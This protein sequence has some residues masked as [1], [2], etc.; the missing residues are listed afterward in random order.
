MAVQVFLRSPVLVEHK[1]AGIARMHVQVVLDAALF[2]AGGFEQSQDRAAKV[3]FFTGFRL[4]FGDNG[5]QLSHIDDDDTSTGD[6]VFFQL[7][8]KG[9]AADSQEVRGDGA[10]PFGVFEGMN[11]GAAF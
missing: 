6:F 1:A 9:G 11:D 5:Q 4:H 7:A 8:I 2:L 3:L 10:V